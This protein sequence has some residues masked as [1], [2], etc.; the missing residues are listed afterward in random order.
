[1]SIATLK[2]KTGA[3]YSKNHTTS[4]GPGLFWKGP[5]NNPNIYGK[6]GFSLNGPY[7]N[8]GYIGSESK[9]SKAFTPFKG[10][11]P[12]GNGGTNGT[13]KTGHISYNV[14][15]FVNIM[16]E[17]HKYNKSSVISTYGMLRERFKWAY[18]G[19]FPMDIIKKDGVVVR[20]DGNVEC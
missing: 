9:F 2:K 8:V 3:V 15:P 5:Y 13:Y 20:C 6:E 7:R 12:V 16:G 18:S 19:E 4:R 11:N 10:V 14:T 1:M 17:Q